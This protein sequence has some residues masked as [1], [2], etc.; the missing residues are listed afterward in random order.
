MTHKK[1]K[2]TSFESRI[3]ALKES[4]SY[5]FL[6]YTVLRDDTEENLFFRQNMLFSSF[7]VSPFTGGTVGAQRGRGFRPT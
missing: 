7:C 5:S 3:Q 2:K 1:I 6:A 4:N